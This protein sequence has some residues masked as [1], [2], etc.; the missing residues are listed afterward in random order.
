MEEKKKGIGFRFERMSFTIGIGVSFDWKT[1]FIA[2]GPFFI[3][4]DW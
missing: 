1:A 4:F 2:I 3:D